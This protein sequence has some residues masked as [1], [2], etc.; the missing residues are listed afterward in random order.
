MQQRQ[1]RRGDMY[2]EEINPE[3]IF[4]MFF[5]MQPGGARRHGGFTHVYRQGQ[6]QRGQQQRQDAQGAGFGNFVQ[7]MPLL[8]LFLFS[9]L[10]NQQGGQNLPFRYARLST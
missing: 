1:R 3:D 4:N 5:G 2:G 7:L 10:G 8:M 9:F 6:Q